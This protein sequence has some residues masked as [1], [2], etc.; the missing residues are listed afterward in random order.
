MST[1]IC[2]TKTSSPVVARMSGSDMRERRDATTRMSLRSSGLRLLSLKPRHHEHENLPNEDELTRR[3]PHER[4][5]YAGTSRRND[6]DVASLIRA[7][8]AFVEAA[9]P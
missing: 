1:R 8:V 2:R 3:S 7:T 5:R 6:P 4:Q 9:S